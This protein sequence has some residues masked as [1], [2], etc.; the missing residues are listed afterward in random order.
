MLLINEDFFE[1]ATLNEDW[2]TF[3]DCILKC[4]MGPYPKGHK[5]GKIF[6]ELTRGDDPLQQLFL[7]ESKEDET[8]VHRQLLTFKLCFE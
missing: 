2:D 3:Y 6:T 7:Y 8:P 5:F 1:Y 4:E